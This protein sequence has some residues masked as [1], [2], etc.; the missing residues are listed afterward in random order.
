M[1]EVRDRVDVGGQRRVEQ[2]GIL[3]AAAG[4]RVVAQPAVEEVVARVAG[5]GVG[6]AVAVAVDGGGAGQ[7]QVL[8]AVDRPGA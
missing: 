6:E 2:E 8:D 7:G 4:Q 1:R 5:Q 3:A